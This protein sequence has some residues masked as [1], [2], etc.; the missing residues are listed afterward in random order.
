MGGKNILF[1]LIFIVIIQ[2]PWDCYSQDDDS[3]AGKNIY[4]PY[5]SEIVIVR[6]TIPIQDSAAI[7]SILQREQ[8]IRDSLLAREI[9]VRDSIIRRQRILD[10]VTFLKN[11]LSFLLPAYFR[12]VRDEIILNCKPIALVGDSALDNFEFI[13]MPFGVREPYSP[14]K[15]RIAFLGK[16]FR[17]DCDESGKEIVSVHTSQM[18]AS[19]IRGDKLL[20]IHR[21]AILQNNSRGQFYK[22]PV[23]SVFFDNRGQIIKI[24]SYVLFH[25]LVNGSQKGKLVFANRTEF[26]LYEYNAL[27]EPAKY[28]VVR[29]CERW[30]AWEPNKVCSILNFTITRQGDTYTLNR[31]NDPANGYSDGTYTLAYDNMQNLKSVSFVNLA[32]TENWQRTIELNK[33]GN[34][35][36]YMDKSGDLILQSL[37]MIYN[38]DPQAKNS[39]ETITTTFEKDGISYYQKNNT[40]GKSRTRDRMTLE[41]GQWK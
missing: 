24:K 34:V 20:V 10:S 32:K 30:K 5:K 25:A 31:R 23:D 29:F 35:S 17:Y 37:C 14:W 39:V 38:K 21:P 16:P 7:D 2:V 19:F 4:R 18:K 41:W 6:D 36:C 27:N 3:V 22:N 15:T 9:F 12:V 33:D 28:Q 26:R 8:F 1:F 11:E 13:T 40:T